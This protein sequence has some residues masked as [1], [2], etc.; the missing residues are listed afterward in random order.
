M[1][2]AVKHNVRQYLEYSPTELEAFKLQREIKRQLIYGQTF[3]GHAFP[4]FE[5]QHTTNPS[6]KK[7]TKTG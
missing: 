3:N 5:T 7:H 2:T 4:R 1:P 6:H